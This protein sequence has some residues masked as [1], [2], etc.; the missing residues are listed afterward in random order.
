VAA[1]SSTSEPKLAQLGH[2]PSQRPVEY[3]HSE[4]T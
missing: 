3:P 1:V 2:L 4:H